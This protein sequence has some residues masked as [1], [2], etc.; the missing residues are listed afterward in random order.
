MHLQTM[1]A[2][3]MLKAKSQEKVRNFVDELRVMNQ[4]GIDMYKKS[5]I[6]GNEYS[7]QDEYVKYFDKKLKNAKSKCG[8]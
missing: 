2:D 1:M 4:D 7:S 3:T 8:Y 6:S 5:N